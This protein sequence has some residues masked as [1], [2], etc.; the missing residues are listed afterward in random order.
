MKTWFLPALTILCLAVMLA[1]C[2]TGPAEPEIEISLAP[3]H[4]VDI[5]IAESAPPQ[6]FVYIK[7]GLRDGCTTFREIK[8]N[9]S[10]DT[11]DIEVTV[12]HPNGKICT[13]IYGYFEKNVALGSEFTSGKTYTVNVNAERKTFVMQ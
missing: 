5:R 12:Q 11:I 4:E 3:I 9:R 6:V 8:T 13:A 7:G 1:G 2:Q 10:G